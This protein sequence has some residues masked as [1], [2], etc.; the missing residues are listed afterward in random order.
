[1]KMYHHRKNNVKINIKELRNFLWQNI[2]DIITRTLRLRRQTIQCTE[3]YYLLKELAIYEKV[4]L[5]YRSSIKR[6]DWETI[7]LT[8]TLGSHK[9]KHTECSQDINSTPYPTWL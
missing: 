1:M 6:H 2:K 9:N 8:L 4:R 5:E 3:K 7:Y